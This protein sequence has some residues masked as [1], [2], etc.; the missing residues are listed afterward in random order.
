MQNT[1]KKTCCVLQ[2]VFIFN[3][4]QKNLSMP[5][6]RMRAWM[7]GVTWMAR[8]V[9][10]NMMPRMMM[11]IMSFFRNLFNVIIRQTST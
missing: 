9:H 4:L 1:Y 8:V 11:L 3:I 6:V 5:V 10:Y 7:A 2:Q